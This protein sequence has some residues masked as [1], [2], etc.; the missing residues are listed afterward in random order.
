M[1][2]TNEELIQRY[3]HISEILSKLHKQLEVMKIGPRKTRKAMWGGS[4][5]FTLLQIKSK[6]EERGLPCV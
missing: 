1:E 6:M 5:Q 3:N 2:E 4:L